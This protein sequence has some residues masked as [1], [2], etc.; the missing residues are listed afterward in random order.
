MKTKKTTTKKATTTTHILNTSAA[1]TGIESNEFY[2]GRATVGGGLPK[3]PLKK[4]VSC[5]KRPFLAKDHRRPKGYNVYATW[6]RSFQRY[7]KSG[8]SECE[9]VME[10]RRG[11]RFGVD[12]LSYCY[13]RLLNSMVKTPFRSWLMSPPSSNMLLPLI[14][15]VIVILT[16]RL[17]A[18][19]QM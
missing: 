15:L 13:A 7:L 6:L 14:L 9:M 11:E 5:S 4:K 8:D 10:R 3:K 12:G 16:L 19:T 1:K 17:S 2:L 18:L